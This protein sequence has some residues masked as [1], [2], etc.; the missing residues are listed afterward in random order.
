MECLK[1]NNVIS[2]MKDQDHEEA[3]SQQSEE[4]SPAKSMDESREAVREIQM[5]KELD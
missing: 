3:S 5:Q 1:E 4:Q 2:E